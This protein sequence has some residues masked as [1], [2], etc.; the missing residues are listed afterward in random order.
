MSDIAINVENVTKIYK[1]YDNKT[2][3]MK[4][5]LGMSRGKKLYKEHYA[6]RDVSMQIKKG[7]TLGIIGTNGSDIFKRYVC[8]TCICGCNKY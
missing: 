3:R 7:E 6:L 1:I 2:D 5:A 8:K 4:D